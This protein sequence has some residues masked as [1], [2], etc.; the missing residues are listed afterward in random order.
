MKKD[1][2]LFCIITFCI[3]GLYFYLNKR[4]VYKNDPMIDKI[5]A[6]LYIIEPSSS[7]FEY[8]ASNES[9]TE[10]KQKIYLCLK[11]EKDNYYDYNMLI[12]V[13]LHELAHALSKVVDTKHETLEFHNTFNILLNR[14][15]DK[16]IYDSSRPLVNQYCV[17]KK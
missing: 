4:V 14:A 15:K 3:I 8:F 17:L 10:D 2:I 13:S 1:I 6:D 12:Y 16:G 7:H 9:Y 11:D 5:K